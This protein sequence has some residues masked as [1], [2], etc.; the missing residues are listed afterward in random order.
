MVRSRGLISTQRFSPSLRGTATGR[1]GVR[2]A[3]GNMY[4]IASEATVRPTRRR[5]GKGG[6]VEGW[7]LE[8]REGLVCVSA[9]GVSLSA[10]VRV[11]ASV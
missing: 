3:T 10:C 5:E 9:E 8:K 4:V 7:G 6:A 1:E 11:C 2:T